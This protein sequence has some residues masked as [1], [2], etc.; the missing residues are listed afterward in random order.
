M[1]CPKLV[2]T[3]ISKFLKG[4]DQI[5]LVEGDYVDPPVSWLSSALKSLSLDITVNGDKRPVRIP[6]LC[7][8]YFI[9]T[10]PKVIKSI[11]FLD[12]TIKSRENSSPLVSSTR[13]VV[14]YENPFGFHFQWLRPP[15]M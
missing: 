9:L 3:L 12:M 11:E 15:Y 1:T 6:I 7:L 4:E 2:G 5:L 8:S 14:I 10:S 13:T